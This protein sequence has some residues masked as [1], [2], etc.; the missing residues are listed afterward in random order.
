M[1]KHNNLLTVLQWNANSLKP[2]IKTLELLLWQEKAHI[3]LI[4]ETW[5]QEEDSI[6]ISDYNIIRQDRDDG[7]GGIC[8]LYHKSIKMVQEKKTF[9]NANIEII[10]VKVGTERS[11]DKQYYLHILSTYSYYKSS[12][13]G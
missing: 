5:L 6:K 7:Y 11:G 13:L 8:I 1:N 9:A 2:K 10:L 12:K 4:S 3:A